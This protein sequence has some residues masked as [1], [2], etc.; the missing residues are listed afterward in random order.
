[1]LRKIRDVRLKTQDSRRKIEDLRPE[2][3]DFR[4]MSRISCFLPCVLIFASFIL[5][6]ECSAD[7]SLRIAG[8]GGAFVGLP[9]AEGAIFG[10]PAG[11]INVRANNLSFALSAQ[12]LNYETTPSEKG[13]Q[14]DNIK[15]SLR[16]T[17]S[18]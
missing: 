10:N 7:E 14:L 16:L 4:L 8:M 11:L 2:T 15:F 1:M 9:S 18:V 17:P 6:L 13:E 12:N 3:S 5:C